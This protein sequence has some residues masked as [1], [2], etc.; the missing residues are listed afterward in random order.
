MEAKN[1]NY[2]IVTKLKTDVHNFLLEH[3]TKDQLFNDLDDKNYLIEFDKVLID[4]EDITYA[5]FILP[6]GK[7]K[8]I[9]FDLSDMEIKPLYTLNYNI[10]NDNIKK[11]I[12][13]FH[14]DID[15]LGFD[16]ERILKL[17]CIRIGCNV[18]EDE[19]YI[20]IDVTNIKPNKTL[21][22]FIESM[23]IQYKSLYI[24]FQ[25][26]AANKDEC[27]KYSLSDGDTIKSI[28]KDI[29]INYNKLHNIRS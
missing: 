23:L 20:G 15:F 22:N 21:L 14:E 28:E 25:K 9:D 2:S 19:C 11:Y 7:I 12:N 26:Q 10:N 24:D 13:F 18:T 1:I 3:K 27:K 4:I 17:G 29:N 5:S 16:L 6:N 8:K